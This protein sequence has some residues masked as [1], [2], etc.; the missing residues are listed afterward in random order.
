LAQDDGHRLCGISRLFAPSA[1]R[2]EYS[3]WWCRWS[4]R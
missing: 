3:R 1:S 2:V 4:H